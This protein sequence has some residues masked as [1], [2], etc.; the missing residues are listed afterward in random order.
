MSAPALK[1]WDQHLGLL[2]QTVGAFPNGRTG[3]NR[4]HT[5]ADIGLGA[6]TG[7]FAP[8]SPPVKRSSTTCAP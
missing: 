4:S 8:I 7:S 3:D 2:R 1:T 6:S 5:M